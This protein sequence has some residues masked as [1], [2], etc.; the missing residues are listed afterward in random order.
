MFADS[1][2]VMEPPWLRDPP[3]RHPAPYGMTDG[4]PYRQQNVR[5][6]KQDLIE[7][8]DA[9]YSASRFAHA[10]ELYTQ[11]AFAKQKATTINE[12]FPY[13]HPLEEE[14]TPPIVFERITSL[15]TKPLLTDCPGAF[16][17]ALGA[18]K[19]LLEAGETRLS[20]Q[21]GATIIKQLKI[22]KLQMDDVSKLDDIVTVLID[23]KFY[24]LARN[25]YDAKLGL[26]AR[27]PTLLSLEQARYREFL[28]KYQDQF[29]TA[30]STP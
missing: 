30:P 9:E 27:D 4:I 24:D 14:R 25:F 28:E 19:I 6:T 1:D 10:L 21:L 26:L 8:A 3:W 2:L 20:A 13:F 22:S 15:C 5:I 29:S 16:P 18:L 12:L 7:F 23:A 17:S 11:A